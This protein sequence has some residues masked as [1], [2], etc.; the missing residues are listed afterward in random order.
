MRWT[1]VPVPY[2][3]ISLG[4]AGVATVLT[5]NV[6]VFVIISCGLIL[7][8]RQAMSGD[9]NRP[10]VLLLGLLSGAFVAER[11]AW[12]GQTYDPLGVPFRA[13]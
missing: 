11:R 7:A 3:I 8:G 1:G 4:V 2:F 10:R 9:H 13:R 5:Y 6:W 12:G